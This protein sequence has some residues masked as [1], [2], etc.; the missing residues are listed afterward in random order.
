MIGIVDYGMGNLFSIKK[1]LDNLKIKSII[2]KEAEVLKKCEKLILPGVG[3]FKTAVKELK[4]RKLWDSL[5]EEA[6]IRKKPILGI[7]LGMQLMAKCSEEG[8]EEGLGW[9]EANVVR[10]KVKNTVKYKIPH[11]GWNLVNIE[12]ESPLFYRIDVSHGFYFIHEYHIVCEAPEDI[13]STTKYEYPFAS[14]IQKENIFGLQ[15]HPE[16]SHEIG[17]QIINNFA[18]L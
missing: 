4:M 2:T 8:N 12:K 6:K 18:K 11:I 9:F 16:K 1:K 15:F 10:F 13:I 14:G 17:E 3:H 7:C 5:H